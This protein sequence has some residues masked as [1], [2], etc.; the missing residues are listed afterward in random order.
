MGPLEVSFT[1]REITEMGKQRIQSATRDIMISKNLFNLYSKIVFSVLIQN[2]ESFLSLNS[3]SIIALLLS[4]IVFSAVIQNLKSKIHNCFL[5]AVL[6]T[7]EV[8]KL[9]RLC[10][11]A[12]RGSTF[13]EGRVLL[14]RSNL[15]Q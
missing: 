13:A 14:S 8:S 3:K 9:M 6:F 5:V 1:S 4:I 7:I 15:S 12:R 2:Q 10:D 11:S